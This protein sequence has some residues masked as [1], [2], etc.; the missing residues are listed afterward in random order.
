MTAIQVLE[1]IAPD[2][3]MSEGHPVAIEFEFEYKRHGTQT[4]IAAL[5]VA[6]GTVCGPVGETRTETDFARFI[7]WVVQ[8]NPGY[9][10]RTYAKVSLISRQPGQ[11]P[12]NLLA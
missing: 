9:R 3:P 4:L 6:T 12:V 7:E 1:R 2:R 8:L 10:V 11:R 5:Q